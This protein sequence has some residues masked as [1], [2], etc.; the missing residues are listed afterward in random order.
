MT[1]TITAGSVRGKWVKS[2]RS[3]R[4]AHP[5][6]WGFTLAPHRGQWRW[7]RCQLSRAVA[8]TISPASRSLTCAPTERT[9]AHRAP[10]SA[11]CSRASL[12]RCR[13]NTAVL[14]S[15]TP[16]KVGAPASG[17]STA[18][19]ESG[20]RIRTSPS[21]TAINVE[22]GSASASVIHCGSARSAAAR[23]IAARDNTRSARS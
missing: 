4:I 11:T 1:S 18:A 13:A 5:A 23:S 15:S 8:V 6:S 17:R 21:L 19:T 22:E 14:F 20:A 12:G 10:W 3:H 16:K 7:A 9:F 2:Q